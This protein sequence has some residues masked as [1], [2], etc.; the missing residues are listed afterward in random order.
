MGKIRSRNITWIS[1]LSDALQ[2]ISKFRHA[3][4]ETGFLRNFT[5][6]SW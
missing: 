2:V 1:V 3:G 6:S 5:H 4:I